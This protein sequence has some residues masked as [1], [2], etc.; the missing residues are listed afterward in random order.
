MHESPE[1]HLPREPAPDAG[2]ATDAS[3]SGADADVAG[4]PDDRESAYGLLQRGLELMRSRHHA[5]A[6]IV[7]ARAA[8]TEPGRGSILEALGRAYFNSR[9]HDR[10]R[11]TFE[12]LLEVD[13]SAHYAHFALGESLRKLGRA[14][15]ARTHLRLAVALEPRSAL[16]RSALRRADPP[17]D[18]SAAEP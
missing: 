18:P 11:E 8:A 13:P 4:D 1:T 15:E 12:R 9:Q 5:Q 7:L 10:A 17:E 3:A 6:A 14:R 16:Y 2:E